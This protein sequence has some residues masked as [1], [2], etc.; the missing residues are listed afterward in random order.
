MSDQTPSPIGPI[1]LL[2]GYVVGMAFMFILFWSTAD[3]IPDCQEDDAWIAVDHHATDAVE[4]QHGVSRACRNVD[5]ML[6]TAVEVYIQNR[7]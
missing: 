4:D 1:M 7:G 5:Q 2:V 6:D 3:H